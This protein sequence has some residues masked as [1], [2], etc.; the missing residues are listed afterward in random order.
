MVKASAQ[1]WGNTELFDI[2]QER[3]SVRS[4]IYERTLAEKWAVN[5]SVHYNN[6]TNFSESDFRPVV[7]AFQDLHAL[8]YCAK[9][10]SLLHMTKIDNT[11][12]NV[13]CNCGDVNWNLVK[14]ER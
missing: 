12:Q 8:F 6:W 7:E 14:K 3:D 2:Y 1:S 13:R 10:G 9:C 11:P 4:Q 5:A